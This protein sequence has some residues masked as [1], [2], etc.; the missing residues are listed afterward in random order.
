MYLTLFY[1]VALEAGQEPPAFAAGGDRHPAGHRHP[2]AH[3][4]HHPLQSEDRRVL[5]VLRPI[6]GLYRYAAR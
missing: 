3:L 5:I 4:R 2:A 1:A 6:L